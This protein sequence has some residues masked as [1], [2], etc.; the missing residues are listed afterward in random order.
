MPERTLKGDRIRIQVDVSP[1]MSQRL[2]NLEKVTG[3][4]SRS[5][6]VKQAL[7][8]YELFIAKAKKRE[9]IDLDNDTLRIMVGLPIDD[10]N[11]T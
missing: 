6:V 8:V 5:D 2:K 4:T 3:V 7:K 1:E 10:A 11:Q 9:G